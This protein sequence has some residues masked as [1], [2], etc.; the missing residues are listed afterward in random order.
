[1]AIAKDIMDALKSVI[2]LTDRVT[3]IGDAVKTLARDVR[4]MNERL[5]RLE[6]TVDIMTRAAFSARPGAVDTT[7]PSASSPR[8]GGPPKSEG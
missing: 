8:L 6:T 7:A 5:I 4:D 2:L 3:S 1:M